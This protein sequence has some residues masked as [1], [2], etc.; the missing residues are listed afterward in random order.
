MP[1]SYET[2]NI[3]IVDDV[4]TNLTIL[5]QTL[6]DQGFTVWVATS[7]VAALNQ[8][9][10]G[11]PDLILLDVQ[12]PEMDGFETCV[13][14]KADLRTQDIPVI[15]M[16]AL[17][18]QANKVEGLSLGAVDYI[19]KPFQEAEVLAR[20]KVH[21]SLR[22]L[23]QSLQREI[24]ERKRVEAELAQA[25]ASLHRLAYMD[26]LTQVANR[27][28]FDQ[29][30][31]QVWRRLQRDHEPLS[32]I[33]CDVDYFK[34]FN[35]HYGHQVGDD[36]LRQVAH[37]IQQSV[38]RPDDLVARYGGEE[39]AI[40]LPA[41][42]AQG[43]E[44]VALAILHQVFELNIPHEFS[45]IS[46]QITLSLG[47]ATVIPQVE[48]SLDDLIELTDKALYRAKEEG[49]NTYCHHDLSQS[50]P[51]LNCSPSPLSLH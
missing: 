43:A 22:E 2:A 45:N 30:I 42:H 20:V 51:S 10:H 36:C 50:P 14:L 9:A 11:L 35:D 24:E 48:Q 25:N 1:D 4:P 33:L 27:Y 23:T 7:G 32:L 37:A 28:R 8:L 21:L 41:T 18:E 17:S 39:F 46:P 40:I 26:G 47:L 19:T 31:E 13:K 44:Q 29:D 12:M 6:R 3:L 15:F 38:H 49:R 34:L 5:A 16:T